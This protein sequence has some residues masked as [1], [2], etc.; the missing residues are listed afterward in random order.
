MGADGG[1]RGLEALVRLTT[2]ESGAIPPNLLIPV[3]EETGLIVRLGTWV[4]SEACRQMRE[5]HTSGLGWIPVAVNVS[6]LQISRPGFAREVRSC[7]HSYG[8]PPQFLEM[9][10]TESVV[11]GGGEEGERQMRDL[12]S[13]GIRFS[14]DD[15][16]T[17]YSSLSYLYLLP[18][19]AIKLDRSF[20]R[21]IG[22]DEGARRLVQAML[23]VA[24]G[25][26]LDVVAEGV[27]TEEQKSILVA[28]G[29]RVMQG[30][31]FARPA[32]A[33][34]VERFFPLG[35]AGFLKSQSAAKDETA[36]PSDLVCIADAVGVTSF[37]EV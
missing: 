34:E 7:L 10:L 27:E 36:A 22:T 4:L 21:A 37:Q 6:P 29:C 13:I 20:V 16:G 3:A 25:L 12:R 15:F 28:A 1:F 5:W 23:G 32:P 31:L 24:D 17:G 30:Y 35:F 11:L 18:V 26:G 14:I 19:D 33:A 2:P 9:E 8:V